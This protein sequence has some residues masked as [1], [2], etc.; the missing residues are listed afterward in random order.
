MKSADD[1][2]AGRSEGRR[3]F[4]KVT[5][6]AGCIAIVAAAGSFLRFLLFIP[7]P[8]VGGRTVRELSWPR[9]RVM[10]AKSLEPLKP[11]IFNYPLVNTPNVLTRLGSNAENGVGPDGDIVAFS[12][13]CQHL[14]C[15]FSFQPTGSS[16]P[17]DP[18]YKA[19]VSEGYCCC[20]GGEYDLVH[21]GKVI[22]GPPPRAVPRVLLEY[23]EATGDI[24]AV[25][26]GPPTIFGHG[27]PGTT[28][29]SSVLSYDL[30]GGEIATE[31]TVLS[32]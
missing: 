20:H 2:S 12:T 31:Q 28:D 6:A 22:G 9:V 10:N 17:C 19:P 24:Y 27:P 14:G 15:Y 7:P 13:I 32:G 25:G 18:A 5:I 26:M 4:L 3:D 23:D 30:Q 11:I 21:S 1:E 29:P 8:T 16:P